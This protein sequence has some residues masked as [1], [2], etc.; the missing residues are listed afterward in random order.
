M[1][2][3]DWF[4][5]A[6]DLFL[7]GSDT[8]GDMSVIVAMFLAMMLYASCGLWFLNRYGAS[9]TKFFLKTDRWIKNNFKST[10]FQNLISFLVRFIVAIGGFMVVGIFMFMS[11]I[12]F[13]SGTAASLGLV[14][15]NIFKD[16]S[17]VEV[18][19]LFF[20][21]LTITTIASS[22]Y[23]KRID[24]FVRNFDEEE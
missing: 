11:I 24:R 17:T 15:N 16:V 13:F 18:I 8:Q 3:N 23:L 22:H 7:E 6:F 4:G 5:I 12:A 14:S 20:C 9:L 21:G 19:I 2:W 1:A 10:S